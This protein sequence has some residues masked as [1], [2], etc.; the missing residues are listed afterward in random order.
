MLIDLS[1]ASNHNHSAQ[2]KARRCTISELGSSGLLSNPCQ[3][4][5]RDLMWGIDHRSSLCDPDN[6]PSQ[7]NVII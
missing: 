1:C 3:V 4:V 2:C 7:L 6:L 5:P